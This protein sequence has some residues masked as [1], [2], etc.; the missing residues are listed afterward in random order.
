MAEDLQD[1]N[2]ARIRALLV[3]SFTVKDLRR[4]CEDRPLFQPIA[5]QFSPDHGVTDMVDEVIDYCRTHLLWDELL[6]EV[7]RK[8]P[9]PY[10]Q[11]QPG[12]GPAAPPP[13]SG[14]AAWLATVNPRGITSPW[15]ALA[16]ATV[17]VAAALAV[18]WL[19]RKEGPPTS[20]PV[21]T[22]TP[23]PT[24]STTPTITPLPSAAPTPSP[25]P[26]PAPTSSTIPTITP[27]PSAAPT[28]SPTSQP[29]PTLS[30]TP[31]PEPYDEL[32]Q[33]FGGLQG[34]LGAPVADPVTR[35]YSVQ[36]F[37]H[38]MMFWR[39]NRWVPDNWIYVLYWGPTDDKS[40]GSS[41]SQQVDTWQAGDPALSCAQAA[42][43]PVG[44][45]GGFGRIWCLRLEV[46]N[47]LGSALAQ[48]QNVKGGWLDFAGGVMLHDTLNG[49]VLVLF[50]DGHWRAF[51][52]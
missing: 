42:P 20:G 32:W 31:L 40:A 16:L 52:D 10:A 30:P 33:R 35:R 27:L 22:P 6:T 34:P 11:A 3:A 39:D 7:A 12:L 48:E 5:A 50:G 46:R 24:S 47:G 4:F 15:R 45:T 13:L 51:S 41:W 18:W 2:I 21:L 44:P 1:Y 25:P 14:P 43:E 29:S 28:P 26:T 23:A 49:R 37:E 8:R 38:G 9:R 17:L 36:E 19:V